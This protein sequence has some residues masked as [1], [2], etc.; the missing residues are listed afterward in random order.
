[1]WDRLT[2]EERD[3]KDRCRAFAAECIRPWVAAC[4]RENRFPK[5]AHQAAH[6]RR[7]INTGFPEALGGQGMPP[8]CLVIGG[9]E[10]AAVCSPTAFTI[11]F[12]HGALR[13]VLLA[14]TA[15]QQ[16]QFVGQLLREG[17]YASLAMSEPGRSGS[18]LMDVATRA[19]RTNHGWVV[20]GEKCMV[21]NGCV[22][23]LFIVLADT[24][25]GGRR[26]GLS[27]FAVPKCEEVEVGPNAEKI[28]F[29]CLTT[30]TVTFRAVEVSEDNLIGKAGD[31]EWTLMRTLDYIRF[32][33]AAVL[34]GITVGA[35]REALPWIE[36]RRVFPGEPLVRKSH[37]QL[38]L[39]DV[40]AEARMVRMMLW[41]AADRLGSGA[42]CSIETAT[43]KLRA[44]RLAV[45]AT[46]ELVQMMGW[47]GIDARAGIEKRLRDARVTTIY[48]GSSEIQLFNLC[49][50]LRRS[51]REHGDV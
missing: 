41:D 37:I 40:M 17:R 36:S 15:A 12:N 50:E 29:R 13:P 25:E 48:E 34:L 49:R 33:G 3:W 7:M 46:N 44:S 18:N 16:Q 2:A 26:T 1:M 31:A 21:G 28:G 6:E 5:E 30:P 4:D 22:A 20:S 19:E 35:L 11:G 24:W 32:G 39:G 47:E 42:P 14:G 23:D 27:F 43:A 10:L 9:E 8:R 38:L 45:R 51:I